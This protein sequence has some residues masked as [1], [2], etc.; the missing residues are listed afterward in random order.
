ME[1]VEDGGVGVLKVFGGAGRAVSVL[2]RDPKMRQELTVGLKR[3]KDFCCF[4]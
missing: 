4:E 3:E 2:S 1:C